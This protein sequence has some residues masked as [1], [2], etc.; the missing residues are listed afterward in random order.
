M[1]EV[2]SLN[3]IEEIIENDLAEGK[4]S[5]IVNKISS[6]AKWLFAYGSRI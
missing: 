1:S 4:Y 6:R 5:S 3:F 2:R